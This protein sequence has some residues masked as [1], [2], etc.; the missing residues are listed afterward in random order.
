M[1]ICTCAVSHL[2]RLPVDAVQSLRK[3]SGRSCPWCQECLPYLLGLYDVDALTNGERLPIVL[4]IT[5]LTSA[6][7]QPAYSGTTID[8]RLVLHPNGG[9]IATWGPTGLGIA[10]GHDALQRGFYRALWSKPVGTATL[11]E[12]TLAG[13]RELFM[14]GNCCQDTLRTFALLGDPLTRARVLPLRRVWVPH[15]GS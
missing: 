6:F 1:M 2:A 8:E 10:H 13:Y 14:R 4:E 15:V 5:C 12:L 7:Q 9:A 11:G 3:R